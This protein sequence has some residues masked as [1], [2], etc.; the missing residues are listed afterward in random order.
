[1]IS[2]DPTKRK[3]VAADPKQRHT[4]KEPGTGLEHFSNPCRGIRMVG[5]TK[6]IR[7][8]GSK[9][10]KIKWRARQASVNGKGSR[11]ATFVLEPGAN[12]RRPHIRLRFLVVDPAE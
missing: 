3:D 7:E 8:L 5:R 9:R 2:W 6:T 12:C 4:N 10:N 1:M 11:M